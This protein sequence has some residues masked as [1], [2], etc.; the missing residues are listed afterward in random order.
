MNIIGDSAISNT[1]YSDR[2]FTH[3]PHFLVTI[4]HLPVLDICDWKT[5]LVNKIEVDEGCCSHRS[6]DELDSTPLSLD[7]VSNALAQATRAGFRPVRE[8]AWYGTYT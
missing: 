1:L 2:D 4:G 5:K 6:K 3:N 8:I 7:I